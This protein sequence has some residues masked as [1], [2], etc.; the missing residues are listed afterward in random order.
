[1]RGLAWERGTD[2]GWRDCRVD[3]IGGEIIDGFAM[4]SPVAVRRQDR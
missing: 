1:M 2:S 3:K 4:I